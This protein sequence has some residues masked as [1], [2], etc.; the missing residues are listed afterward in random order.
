MSWAAAESR[1]INNDAMEKVTTLFV[2]KVSACI[3]ED[4]LKKLFEQFGD[5][6]KCSI[7]KHPHTGEPRGFAFI[8]FNDRGSCLRAMTEM[9]SVEFFGQKLSVVL[10]KPPATNQP[11]KPKTKPPLTQLFRGVKRGISK[12]SQRAKNIFSAVNSNTGEAIHLDPNQFNLLKQHRT[13]IF[14][15]L[16]GT[17]SQWNETNWQNQWAATTP[18]SWSHF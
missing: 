15:Q 13:T 3:T 4:V 12:P 1:E 16:Q 2:S 17:S 8:E 10:A 9:E 5:I 6:V 14:Q 7:V 18:Q 11:P